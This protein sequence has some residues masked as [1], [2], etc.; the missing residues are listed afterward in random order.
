MIKSKIL[1][2]YK[3]QFYIK[4]HYTNFSNFFV[5]YFSLFFYFIFS[6]VFLVFKTNLHL[7]FHFLPVVMFH[8]QN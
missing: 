7:T 4:K 8:T 2:K 3:S 5:N 1:Q 6:I